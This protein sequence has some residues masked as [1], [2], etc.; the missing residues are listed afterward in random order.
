M[1]DSGSDV[2]FAKRIA[3]DEVLIGVTL[4]IGMFV[5]IAAFFA[6]LS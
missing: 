3:A 4:I 2:W 5:G 6:A 1:L